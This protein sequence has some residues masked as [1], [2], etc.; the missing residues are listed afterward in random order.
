M[1]AHYAYNTIIIMNVCHDLVHVGSE[2]T[3]SKEQEMV[4]VGNH[5]LSYDHCLVHGEC[6]TAI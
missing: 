6:V 5:H 4:F 3:C 2:L 1:H